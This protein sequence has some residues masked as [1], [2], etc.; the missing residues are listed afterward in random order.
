LNAIV[1]ALKSVFSRLGVECEYCIGGLLIPDERISAIVLVP[2]SKGLA[3]DAPSV[4]SVHTA[5]IANNQ[6][7]SP[8]WRDCPHLKRSFEI[9]W[10]RQP[11]VTVLSLAAKFATS[12]SEL[13]EACEIRC[14]FRKQMDEG[15]QIIR[16]DIFGTTS[17]YGFGKRLLEGTADSQDL[18]MFKERLGRTHELL[19]ARQ[20]NCSFI[21]VQRHPF[22]HCLKLLA[23]VCNLLDSGKVEPLAVKDLLSK[24]R[25]SLP[26]PRV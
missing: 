14:V 1:T 17:T 12:D 18:A 4:Q 11:L 22:P 25:Q 13:A 10:S 16:H 23:A 9:R 15:I 5:F 21:S 26:Q 7:P 20:V 19:S 24:I 3:F 8:L 2:T 6:Q